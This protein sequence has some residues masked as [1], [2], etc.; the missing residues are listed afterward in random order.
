MHGVERLREAPQERRDQLP[1]F[2][3]VEA[4]HVERRPAAVERGLERATQAAGEHHT[5][6]GRKLRWEPGEVGRAVD[7]VE[8][9]DRVDGDDGAARAVAGSAQG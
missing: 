8:V 4:G 1:A 3:F 6:V 5:H 2:A 7:V 9:V